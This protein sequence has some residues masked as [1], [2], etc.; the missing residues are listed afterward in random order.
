M[1]LLYVKHLPVCEWRDQTQPIYSFIS[2]HKK[3]PVLY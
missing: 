1:F 2:I 3:V